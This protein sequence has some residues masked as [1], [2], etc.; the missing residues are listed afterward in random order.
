MGEEDIEEVLGEKITE[1]TLEEKEIKRDR[2]KLVL[3]K[4][5]VHKSSSST[6]KK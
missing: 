5:N 6:P 3:K 4:T 2:A 1:K